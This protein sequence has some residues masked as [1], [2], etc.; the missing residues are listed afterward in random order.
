[1]K[2]LAR[3]LVKPCAWKIVSRCF[4]TSR[5]LQFSGAD[6]IINPSSGSSSKSGLRHDTVT[7]G[8][9]DRAGAAAGVT[10]AIT[11]EELACGVYS[12]PGSVK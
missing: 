8:G 6:T 2:L 7:S 5:S 11:A 1:M 4:P 12:M 9:A 10:G 3:C